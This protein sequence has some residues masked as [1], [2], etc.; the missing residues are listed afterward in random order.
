[1]SEPVCAVMGVVAGH[2]SACGDCDPCGAAD[3]VSEPVKRL[4]A[5]LREWMDKYAAEATDFDAYRAAPC[6]CCGEVTG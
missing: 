2:P 6:P 5:E 4:I 3:R 1:M